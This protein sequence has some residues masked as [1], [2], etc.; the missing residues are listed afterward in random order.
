MS[1]VTG[2]TLDVVDRQLLGR[3]LVT[4]S[5]AGGGA[6]GLDVVHVVVQGRVAV[7][8]TQRPE[9]GVDETSLVVVKSTSGQP[10]LR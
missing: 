9:L 3:V 2:R 10:L 8:P 5:N 7:G 1:E 4:E 6:D